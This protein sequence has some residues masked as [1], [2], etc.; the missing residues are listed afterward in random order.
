MRFILAAVLALSLGGSAPLQAG[1][2]Q[3][4]QANIHFNLALKQYQANK[5]DD[6]KATLAKALS[7]SP[8]HPQANFLSG[9]IANQQGRFSDA[10]APLKA[11]AKGMPSNAEVQ[12][13][14]GI[15]YFQ[16]G[17]DEEADEAFKKAHYVRR[18]RFRVQRHAAMFM[19]PRGFVAEWDE[20][21]GKL[22]VWGAAKTAWHNRRTLA[23]QLGLDIDAVDLI[24]V[25]VGGGF[26]SRGEFYPE[27]YLIPA[28]AR[29]VGRPVKWTEDRREHMMTANH[30]RDR[31][32]SARCSA[33]I[34]SAWALPLEVHAAAGHDL[35]LDD[36]AWVAA[37]IV[38]WYVLRVC[39]AETPEAAP[40][41]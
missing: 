27:D 21:K 40:H 33:A 2:A 41:R 36:P 17:K 32:V 25:D 8:E 7:L 3:D 39:A 34:A 31:L 35:P 22:T 9:L 38:E 30:A 19:E 11:A 26:G 15:A 10:I 1:A 24:E 4:L 14:L 5:L 12:Q 37:R 23:A 29:I 28:A 20:V 16:L 13:S 18:E 6:A